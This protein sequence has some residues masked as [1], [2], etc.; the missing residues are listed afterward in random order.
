V[1]RK[2]LHNKIQKAAKTSSPW[3]KKTLNIF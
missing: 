1:S 2:E 3:F